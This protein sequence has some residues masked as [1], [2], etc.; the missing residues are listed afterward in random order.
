MM[1]DMQHYN[2][3]NLFSVPGY[4]CLD[5]IIIIIINVLALQQVVAPKWEL[6]DGGA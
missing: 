4:D 3:C 6:V 2:Y 5:H 1:D